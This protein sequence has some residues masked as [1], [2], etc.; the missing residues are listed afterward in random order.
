MPSN[1]VTGT[2]FQ[3]DENTGTQAIQIPYGNTL[4]RFWRITSVANTAPGRTASLQQS[5]LGYEWDNSPDNPFTPRGLIYLSS[6]TV[7]EPSAFNTDW[8][9]VDTGGTSTNNLVEYRDPTS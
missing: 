4:L 2:L 5:L 3:V 9:N 6:T 7:F 8:G 1:Q